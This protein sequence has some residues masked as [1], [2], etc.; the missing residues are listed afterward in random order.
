MTS[1]GSLSV[2]GG[3]APS[4]PS[5]IYRALIL[6][7]LLECHGSDGADASEEKGGSQ[8]GERR[9]RVLAASAQAQVVAVLEPDFFAV[10]GAPAIFL[11]DQFTVHA[12]FLVLLVQDRVVRGLRE[13]PLA[14]TV[15]LLVDFWFVF[16]GPPPAAVHPV[17]VWALE[18]APRAEPIFVARA[19]R[20]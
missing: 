19:L 6:H 4:V 10:V 15:R 8:A 16:A 18:G 13:V 14:H 1:S 20:R 12:R 3:V 5:Y 9:C 11:D 2:G 7:N 17:H